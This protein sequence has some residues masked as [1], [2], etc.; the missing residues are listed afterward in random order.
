[1]NK[2]AIRY[3]LYMFAGFA[4]LF[5]LMHFLGLSE[6]YYLRVLNGIIHLGGIYLAIAAYKRSFDTNN[7]SEVAIGIYTSMIGVVTFSIFM[8]LFLKTDVAF[9]EGL[10][11]NMSLGNYLTPFTATL[12][13]FA[14][15]LVI[16]LIGSYIISRAVEN[17]AFSVNTQ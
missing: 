6:N 11:E 10:R 1:M 4:L 12:F 7:L 5:L 13:I 8:Y 9:M 3:G 2:I 15:G 14:E 16:S 17:V